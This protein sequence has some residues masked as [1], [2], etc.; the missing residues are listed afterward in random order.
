MTADE[1]L[2]ECQLY[3]ATIVEVSDD[4]L[5][6]DVPD[7]FPESLLDALHKHKAELIA[8]LERLPIC[9]NPLTPHERHQLPWECDP[10]TCTCYRNFGWPFWCGGAPCRWVWPNGLSEEERWQ[11]RTFGND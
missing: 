11:R 9:F 2:K 8:L 6:F 3:G 10:N 5:T 1:L 4:R 7:D